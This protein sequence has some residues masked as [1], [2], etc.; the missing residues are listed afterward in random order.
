MLDRWYDEIVDIG[1]HNVDCLDGVRG[2]EP[3]ARRVLQLAI[4]R[5][6]RCLAG[7]D[8]EATDADEVLCPRAPYLPLLSL[9][10]PLLCS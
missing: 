1:S 3:L 5:T 9:R 10:A 2:F 6:K 8:V 4:S 7:N